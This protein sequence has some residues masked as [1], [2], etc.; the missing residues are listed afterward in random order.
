M[1]RAYK[2]HNDCKEPK[3]YAFPMLARKTHSPDKPQQIAAM[4]DPPS[5]TDNL[6]AYRER[7]QSVLATIKRA[8]ANHRNLVQL[9]IIAEGM[10]EALHY[11]EALHARNVTDAAIAGGSIDAY[12]AADVPM[13]VLSAAELFAAELTL[14]HGDVNDNARRVG[15]SSYR[16]VE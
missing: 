12:D 16:N 6:S 14:N 4:P 15:R 10:A 2:L 8:P 13:R 7:L 11:V 5:V 1:A 3:R 9:H